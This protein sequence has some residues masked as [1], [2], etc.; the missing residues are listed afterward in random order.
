[1]LKKS[2]EKMFQ[3]FDSIPLSSPLPHVHV[4]QNSSGAYPVPYL[5]GSRDIFLRGKAYEVSS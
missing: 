5:V 3:N 2:E 4:F 1:V